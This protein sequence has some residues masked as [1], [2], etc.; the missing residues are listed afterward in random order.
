M[1]GVDLCKVCF[2]GYGKKSMQR[3]KMSEVVVMGVDMYKMCFVVYQ[4]NQQST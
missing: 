3:L 4:R 2:I 1:M